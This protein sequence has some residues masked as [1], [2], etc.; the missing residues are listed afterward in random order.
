M[1]KIVAKLP[2]KEGNVETFKAMAKELVAKSATEEGNIFYTLNESIT[3]PNLLAFI[4][5]WKDQAAVDFHN[6]T[7][8][9]TSILPKLS[10]LCDG[11]VSIDV[12]NEVEF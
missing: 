6:N 1:I 8:H 3:T 12:F 2:V 9:F 4:E 5:C 10:A 7:E 11:E